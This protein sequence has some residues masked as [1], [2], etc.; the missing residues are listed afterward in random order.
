M[1]ALKGHLARSPLA[2]L[3][4]GSPTIY[5]YCTKSLVTGTD[6]DFPDYA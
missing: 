1:I 3:T 6:M 2:V 4:H 5:T